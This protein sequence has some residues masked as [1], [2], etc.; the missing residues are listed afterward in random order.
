MSY[1]SEGIRP[2]ITIYFPDNEISETTLQQLRKRFETMKVHPEALVE[3]DALIRHY[4]EYSA[5]EFKGRVIT[6]LERQLS[7]AAVS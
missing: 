5:D 6:L 4:K 7:A 1:K 2:E 3:L